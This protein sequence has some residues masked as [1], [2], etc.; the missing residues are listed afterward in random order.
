MK[1]LINS[2]CYKYC[3][4][5]VVERM[6]PAITFLH[7]HQEIRDARVH[8]QLQADLAAHLW[9][10]RRAANNA[11][12]N[13]NYCTNNFIS[14]CVKLYQNIVWIISFLNLCWTISKYCMNNLYDWYVVSKYCKKKNQVFGAAVWGTPVWEHHPQMK[15]AVPPAPIWGAPVE[16]LLTGPIH[17]SIGYRE[18]AYI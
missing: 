13:L 9:A 17:S 12:F 3:N 5:P 11:W 10:R 8:A 18:L 7:M 15:D 2:C 16:M 6:N 4:N 14:I 1:F